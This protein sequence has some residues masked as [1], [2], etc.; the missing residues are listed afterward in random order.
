[1][2]R[3]HVF[4]NFFFLLMIRRPPRST[5]FPY[6]TLF[7]SAPAHHLNRHCPEC[8]FQRSCRDIATSKDDL[9][10]LPNMHKREREKQNRKGFFT[11][12]QLSYTFR[13]RR[14]P[15]KQQAGSLLYNHSLKA[16]A[17]RDNKI[18]SERESDKLGILRGF[19]DS[20]HS[21]E[22]EVADGQSLGLEQQVTQILV[23]A[24]AIDEHPNVPVDSFH[25][26]HPDLGPAVVGDAV[27]VFQ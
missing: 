10:L 7:R 3:S 25:H 15:S 14:R 18:R 17:I 24:P 5:L 27:Q 23:A 8:A 2:R 16:L 11:V 21:E 6:A 22:F 26:T 9:S 13:P 4:I 12:T 20:A 19:P 1:M